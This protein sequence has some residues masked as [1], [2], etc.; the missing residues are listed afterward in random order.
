MT[1]KWV[2]H[3]EFFKIVI[4]WYEWI[5]T[6]KS[7]SFFICFFNLGFNVGFISAVALISRSM[8][9]M[10]KANERTQIAAEGQVE[11]LQEEDSYLQKEVG[12]RWVPY[13]KSRV[14]IGP[15]LATY[16]ELNLEMPAHVR[17]P[18]PRQPL[19]VDQVFLNNVLDR[20]KSQQI[21]LRDTREVVVTVDQ[22]LNLLDA[23][24]TD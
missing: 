12:E 14:A 23:E 3:A 6:R 1:N 5:R 20:Y 21:A 7:G 16:D 10:I 19:M 11:E 2:T 15:Y 18:R 4:C 22:I 8:G 17:Q 13:L 24:I 9:V